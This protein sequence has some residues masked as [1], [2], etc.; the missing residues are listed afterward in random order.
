MPKEIKSHLAA[1]MFTDIV[2]FTRIMGKDESAGIQ[3]LENQ[4]LLFKDITKKYS[5][6][7]IKKTGDGYLI[8]FL[9]SVDAV[10]CGIDM[11][12]ALKDYNENKDNIE[13]HIRIGI[14]LGDIVL[15]E[16]DILGD[17][18]NIASRIQPLA[19][20]DGIC[21]TESVYHSVKSTL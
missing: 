12:D 6:T 18:V 13:F 3:I 7:V 16:N 19:N 8:E 11:Q 5:G 1:I 2:E 17:G 10:Q 9:S 21:L 15:Y 20:A 4:E 14:H